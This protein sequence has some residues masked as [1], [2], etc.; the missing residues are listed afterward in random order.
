MG[1]GDLRLLTVNEQRAD[2]IFHSPASLLSCRCLGVGVEGE[3]LWFPQALKG[4]SAWTKGPSVVGSTN[5][6]APA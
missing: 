1:G 3:A 6:D 5:P 2:P 4:T